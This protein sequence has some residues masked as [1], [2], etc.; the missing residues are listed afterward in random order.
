MSFFLKNFQIKLLTLHFQTA[1]IRL[2]K[3]SPAD[4][5]LKLFKK[6]VI[7]IQNGKKS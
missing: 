1:T 3:L 7:L 2:Q 6:N 4:I 5:I